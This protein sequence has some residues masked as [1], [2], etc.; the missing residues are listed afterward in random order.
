MA[1]SGIPARTAGTFP[2]VQV[3]VAPLGQ[4]AE[5]LGQEDQALARQ[6]QAGEQGRVEDEVDREAGVGGQ[7]G[8]GVAQ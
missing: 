6:T 1:A 5:G 4:V 2:A 7:R 3:H 8:V